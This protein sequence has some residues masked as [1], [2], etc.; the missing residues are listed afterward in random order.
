MD[1]NEESKKISE[2]Q[3]LYLYKYGGR[4]YNH[5]INFRNEN[6]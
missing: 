1:L 2:K 3:K 4:N 5:R 6:E